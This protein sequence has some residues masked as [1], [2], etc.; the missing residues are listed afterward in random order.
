MVC[1]PVPIATA[2]IGA[3]RF[4][5]MTQRTSTSTAQMLIGTQADERLDSLFAVLR[6]DIL[7]TEAK[8]MQ[9]FNAKKLNMGFNL[10]FKNE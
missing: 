3:V 9:I 1:S 5:S 7:I 6:I 2:S 10:K 8:L 4:L